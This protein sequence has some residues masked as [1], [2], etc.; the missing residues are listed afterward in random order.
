VTTDPSY[1]FRDLVLDQTELLISSEP[2]LTGGNLLRI[3]P[4]CADKS[5]HAYKREIGRLDGVEVQWHEDDEEKVFV[6]SRV[7]E[8]RHRR[9]EKANE[10]LNEVIRL[11]QAA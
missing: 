5:A 6:V 7:G 8:M 10:A 1:E 2:D 4:S 9:I 3:F 11:L